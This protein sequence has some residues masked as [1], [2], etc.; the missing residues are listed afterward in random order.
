[1]NTLLN[2]EDYFYLKVF[3]IIYSVLRLITI[4]QQSGLKLE[5]SKDNKLFAEF[6]EKSNITNLIY[7]P[8]WTCIAPLV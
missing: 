1:M 2:F 6:V 5:Y 8:Y 3:L 4:Y 7:R